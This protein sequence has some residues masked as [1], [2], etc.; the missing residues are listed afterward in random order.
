MS[1]RP[2]S[3]L[4]VAVLLVPGAALAAHGKA[5]L[6]SSTTTMTMPGVPPQSH[7]ATYCMTPA[8]VNSEAPMG[9]NPDCTY[10]NAHVSGQTYTADMVCK[11]QF[12][13]TGHFTSTYSGDSQYTA[14]ITINTG[15]M[16]MTNTVE[17]K[18]LKA[19]C[20]GATQ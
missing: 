8:Q 18:W 7:S 13:A 2:V 9:G 3:F 20:A 16:T 4:L 19:D 1:A 12:N 5:G 10:L 11:G 15:D 14:T 6:W 17:G